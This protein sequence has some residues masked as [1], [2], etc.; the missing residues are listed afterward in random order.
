M[1]SSF[2]KNSKLALKISTKEGNSFSKVQ[3][4]VKR[5]KRNDEDK[6]YFTEIGQALYSHQ[7]L[8]TLS[9]MPRVLGN[10]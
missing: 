5:E 3:S 2:K 4:R 7:P 9:A 10:K 8:E 6:K 1:A